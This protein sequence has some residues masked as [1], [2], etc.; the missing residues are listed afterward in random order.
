MSSEVHSRG[1][2]SPSGLLQR[3]NASLE[4]ATRTSAPHHQHR[5]DPLQYDPIPEASEFYALFLADGLLFPPPNPHISV[6]L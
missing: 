6:F 5:T 1:R 2:N 3:A 4:F